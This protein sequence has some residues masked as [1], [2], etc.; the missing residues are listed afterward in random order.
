M[1]IPALHEMT[2][3]YNLWL[4]KDKDPTNGLDIIKKEEQ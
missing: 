2:K 4:N 1:K 3:I